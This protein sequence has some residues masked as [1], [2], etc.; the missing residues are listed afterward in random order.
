MMNTN[1]NKWGLFTEGR[2]WYNLKF[3]YELL[4]LQYR[5][6]RNHWSNCSYFFIQ[7]I[8]SSTTQT[9]KT[10]LNHTSNS[11]LNLW[12]LNTKRSQQQQS[13]FHYLENCLLYLV[14]KNKSKKQNIKMWKIDSMITSIIWH[15]W[16]NRFVGWLY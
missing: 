16:L 11:D 2:A 12:V 8:N 10:F 4:L 7:Q 15:L 14:C 1:V 13:E 5:K 3:A 9:T 6:H